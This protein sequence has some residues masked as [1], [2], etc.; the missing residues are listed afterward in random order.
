MAPLATA[1]GIFRLATPRGSAAFATPLFS[2]GRA[3]DGTGAAGRGPVPGEDPFDGTHHRG[4][5]ED[6][7]QQL[8]R[9]PRRADA[10]RHAH[11]GSE[12]GDPGALLGRVGAPVRRAWRRVKRE[13]DHP[14]PH[15]GRRRRGRAGAAAVCR[16]AVLRGLQ[17][18][19]AGRR[20]LEARA[21][22]RGGGAEGREEFALLT[23]RADP[24]PR[25]RFGGRY[26]RGRATAG[27]V[28]GLGCLRCGGVG[29]RGGGGSRGYELP[30]KARGEP[31][32]EDDGAR[33]RVLVCWV[34][35][36]HDHV[37]ALGCPRRRLRRI[38]VRHLGQH[39]GALPCRAAAALH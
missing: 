3:R 5:P 20:A 25:R 17:G 23:V 14:L 32:L 12:A 29:D 6:A 9:P 24:R 11:E 28:E 27:A 35:G 22:A 1:L 7:L 19:R 4:L 2:G 8:T 18:R 34:E 39:Q 30:G 38:L 10:H 31:P 16:A 36:Q 26:S 21:E 37:A 33:R 15:Q 13:A